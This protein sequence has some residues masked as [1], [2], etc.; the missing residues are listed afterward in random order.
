M[1]Q[2]KIV[3]VH[4]KGITPLVM[5]CDTSCNPL[6]PLTKQIKEIT[7]ERKKTDELYQKLFELEFKSRAFYDVDL[8]LYI[9]SKMIKGCLWASARQYKKGKLTKGILLDEAIGYPLIPYKGKTLDDLYQ[10]I[11][12][13]GNRVYSFQEN[14]AVQ[15]TRITRVRPR[16]SK[17]EIKFKMFIDTDLLDVKD[18]HSLLTNAGLY[19]GLGDLRPGLA[20]GNYGKF[21]VVEFNE[22]KK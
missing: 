3:S 20:T 4:V 15:T 19:F 17:W 22:E 2:V 7:A 1:D 5:N 11:D 18:V 10:T 8:G 6:H 12:K 21:E 13:N 14:L 16:F 9:P